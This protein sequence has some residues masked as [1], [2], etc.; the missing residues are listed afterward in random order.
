MRTLLPVQNSKS[1]ENRTDPPFSVGFSSYT[2]VSLKHRTIPQAW[3]IKE[4]HRN[5]R[6]QFFLFKVSIV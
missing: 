4:D 1:Q 5:V 2:F 3:A 6:L